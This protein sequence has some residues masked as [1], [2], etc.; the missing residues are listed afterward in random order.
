MTPSIVQTQPIWGS[1]NTRGSANP[2]SLRGLILAH[3]LLGDAGTMQTQISPNDLA[4]ECL[5]LVRR[6][7]S[8]MSRMLPN[9]VNFDDL[10]GAG[11]LGLATA[12]AHYDPRRSTQ[13]KTYAEFRIR[14]Q[15]LDEL[16]RLDVLSRDQRSWSKRIRGAIQSLGA[17][18]GRE[19]SADEVAAA[20]QLSLE[21]Y[22]ELERDLRQQPVSTE[23][24]PTELAVQDQPLASETI[25]AREFQGQL[26]RAITRLPPQQQ[27][28]LRLHYLEER[29]LQEIGSRLGVTPSR[30]CQ[31]RAAA[32]NA[33]RGFLA[34]EEAQ[35]TRRAA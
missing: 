5:P 2:P 4:V 15:V 23:T 3:G 1:Q 12:I 17:S 24:L 33:L 35:S 25:E 28:V 9:H 30:I 8:Q 18:L 34:E 19:P 11:M 16:R 29:S 20:L 27:L 13:F 26:G 6:V 7:V 31:I 21:A 14:G 22:R 10:M 32:I